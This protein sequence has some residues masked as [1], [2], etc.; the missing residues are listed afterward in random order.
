[1]EAA[2]T[3]LIFAKAPMFLWTEAT[4]TACYTLNRS[5]IHTLHGK[6]YYEL[7]K[8]K[9]PEVNYFRVFGSLCYPT[10]DYDDLGKLKAKADI[11]LRL[12]SMAPEHINAGSDVNHY[13]Q[14]KW[15]RTSNQ[16]PQTPSFPLIE[17]QLSE[18]FQP[19]YDEDEEFPPKDSEAS[20]SGT[21]NV[22]TTHLNNPPLEH[23]QKWT[24]DHSLEN[25]IGDINRSV[26][27]RRQLK[28]D[29]MWCFFNGFL[30]NFELKN[31]KEVVQY[32]CWIDAMQDE[33]HK[34]ERLAVW[35]PVP[36]PLH[37]IV[38][39]LK[40]VYKIKLDEYG[41]V[42]K[43]KARLVAKGY[44]Q[45]AGIDF[46]ESFASMDVKIAFLN[47]ELNEVV[48]VS[49][50]LKKALYG[51]KQAP[52][53]WHD[54]LSRFFMSTGFSKGVV[55]PTLF[56][57]KTSKHILL[58]QI[59]V[60]DII[61]AS[62]NPKSCEI[63]ANEMSSTFKMSMMGQM[64]FFLGLQISQNPKGIF[65]NQS[66]YALEILKKYGL[67]SSASV[68]TPMV[69]KMKLDEDRQGKLVDPTRF[70]GMVG[71]LMYLSA[72]RP[73]IVFAVC[74]C[75]R[76]QAKPTE[77]HLHAIKRIFRYL[78]G[79][80]HMDYAGCQDTRRSTSGSAQFLR[81]K[82]ISWS[83]K[84][85]KSTAIS[86]TEAEYIALSGCC[87]QIL[88]M[89]SQLS[90]YGF[91]FNKIP[92]YCDNQSAI[93]LCCN[94]V[95]H[96]RSK[97][98]DIRH[99]FIK[100]QVENRVVEVVLL[101]RPNYQLANINTKVITKEMLRIA[102]DSTAWYGTKLSASKRTTQTRNYKS[103][104]MRNKGISTVYTLYVS[105]EKKIN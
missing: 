51:L 7:L 24:K 2:R 32:P 11:G 105:T 76:Y 89:R 96:S 46:E 83:S 38:I 59:Y 95:Q 44:H 78:K 61:F 67:D 45:E 37:S 63:F 35:E 101:Y 79:T 19:L 23:A 99:H 88:W 1:M 42:L 8:G 34:F 50:P 10:N 57:R 86:T 66:K 72:S 91:K 100:E 58:V 5:L 82:L 21:V 22:D 29:A 64:S 75:A 17:K 74:M 94:N 6:T 56:T 16:P 47:G 90:D 33:I 103:L 40:W 49:Q 87:A 52:R 3:M 77:K 13:S 69:E 36:A 85:Q 20:S 39:R 93:A 31:F 62:T 27:T 102:T 9:K 15:V 54:K 53:A 14:D 43:N 84:K 26:S 97:H 80:I 92:L 65:I 98:I 28:T 81:D 104:P 30:E 70:R 12:N 48:Y 71:S 18:L 25:V 41:H 68:D 73:D 4:A 60:D 55:Y